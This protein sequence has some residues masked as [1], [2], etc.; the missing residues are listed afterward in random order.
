MSD[1]TAVESPSPTPLAGRDFSDPST[2]TQWLKGLLIISFLLDLVATG[3]GA[4]ELSLLRSF[5]AGTA[6]G[7]IDALAT[8]NDNRQ[9]AVGIIQFIFYVSTAIVFLTWTYRAN[10]NARALGATE[11]KFTPGWSVGWFFVP[12]ASLWKPFQVMREIWQTSAE[13]GNW[14]GVKTPPLLGWWW[15]LYLV[16]QILI[17]VSYRTANTVNDLGSALFASSVDMVSNMSSMAL[18]VLAF[19]LITKIATNQIWQAKTVEVF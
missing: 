1:S 18:D 12:I 11:M 7:D 4:M 16:T 15:A 19:F 10:R 2:L 8:A 6:G 5:Q 17:Q 13:P 3:S 14:Q 9:Q